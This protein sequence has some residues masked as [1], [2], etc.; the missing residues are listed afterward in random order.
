MFIC[1]HKKV[2]LL[3]KK[4][5]MAQQT[6]VRAEFYENSSNKGKPHEQLKTLNEKNR[7]IMSLAFEELD[8]E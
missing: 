3:A 7:T 6:Y 5:I 1:A 8:D 4:Y 2:L